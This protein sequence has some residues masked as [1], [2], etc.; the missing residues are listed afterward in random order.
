LFA[1]FFATLELP[2]L[3]SKT[4]YH[5]VARFVPAASLDTEVRQ[6]LDR[7]EDI[8]SRARPAGGIE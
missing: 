4:D 3:L 1:K 7:I 8:A 5:E 6:V 2:N